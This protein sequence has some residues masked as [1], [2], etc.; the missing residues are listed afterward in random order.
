MNKIKKLS[1]VNELLDSLIVD[2]ETKLFIERGN[3]DKKLNER[4]NQKNINNALFMSK[5]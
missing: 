1:E 2:L 4:K 3:S 5:D